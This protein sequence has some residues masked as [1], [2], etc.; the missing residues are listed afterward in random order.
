[1]PLTRRHFL[2]QTSTAFAAGAMPALVSSSKVAAA[3]DYKALVCVFLNGGNDAWN[4]VAPVSS[5]EYS[6]YAS[7]RGLGESWGL[8]LEKV[9]F[10]PFDKGG[11]V[12][13]EGN[14][15]MHPGLKACHTLY[16]EGDLAIVSG[17]GP[18]VKPTTK[19]QYLASS[20]LGENSLNMNHPLPSQLFGHN[21]QVNQWHTLNGAQNR[22]HGWAGR[23]LDALQ[24]N[25]MNQMLPASIST[26]GRPQLLVGSA[27]IPYV[28]DANGIQR[29]FGLTEGRY[30]QARAESYR[31]I[32][33]AK[34]ADGNAS[35]YAKAFAQ[36][37]ASALENALKFQRALDNAPEFKTFPNA[38]QAGLA[39]QLRTVAKIISARDSFNVNRQIFFVEDIGFD[40]HDHQ[41]RDQPRLLSTLDAALG[42]FSEALKS[43]GVWDNVVT[44]T[45]SDFG[46]TLTSNGDGSD[47]GWSGLQFVVGGA[48]SGGEMVGTYPILELDRE[49]EIGN[50]IFIPDISVDQYAATLS[51]WFGVPDPELDKVC[52]QLANFVDRDLGFL[53]KKLSII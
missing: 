23:A 3:S 45:Q 44:F 6:A 46:R 35:I 4:T 51:H 16:E 8:A 43:M 31:R 13:A 17:I 30:H 38:D 36:V 34:L 2:R 9:Q 27:N 18:L 49:D 15:G 26:N 50:G 28:L 7:A 21:T 20:G 22:P 10:Q 1:M 12:E 52:P 24:Y 39:S 37:Q 53:G 41:M 11:R 33:S 5:P 40:L 42:G 14:Y 32:M 25:L 19:A 29:F 48:V 47:H